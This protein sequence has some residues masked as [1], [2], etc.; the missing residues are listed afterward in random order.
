VLGE[1]VEEHLA[2]VSHLNAYSQQLRRER[3]G[4][5]AAAA[6]EIRTGL[7]QPSG[8]SPPSRLH[9]PAGPPD[10]GAG[11]AAGGPGFPAT[12]AAG[13]QSAEGLAAAG[14]RF[15]PAAAR[16][17]AHTQHV[18]AEIQP[19]PGGQEL[20]VSWTP[21]TP[22][23]GGRHAAHFGT[24]S[25]WASGMDQQHSPHIH[26]DPCRPSVCLCQYSKPQHA[27]ATMHS[28]HP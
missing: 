18:S 7:A 20:P 10:A 22:Q 9:Q 26:G 4:G 17:A 23:A 24:G 19:A 28:S 2:T 15:P 8:H 6:D 21:H 25:R 5:G 27:P 14:A 13:F 12:A 11:G 1:N 3:G 16:Q